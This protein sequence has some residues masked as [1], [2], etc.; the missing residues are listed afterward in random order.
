MG[1]SNLS[2]ESSIRPTERSRCRCAFFACCDF[3]SRHISILD[4]VPS[5]ICA[6]SGNFLDDTRFPFGLNAALNPA[7]R[8]SFR[9]LL[10]PHSLEVGLLANLDR[11]DFAKIVGP[12]VSWDSVKSPQEFAG[13]SM[14]ITPKLFWV[15][16]GAQ[17]TC[18]RPNGLT[19]PFLRCVGA[20][21][22]LDPDVKSGP[23]VESISF[24]EM[25]R[26]VRGTFE[27]NFPACDCCRLNFADLGRNRLS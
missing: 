8:Q 15:D 21:V 13:S 25:F 6:L 11:A 10:G 24:E 20:V 22:L 27:S 2:L 9:F 7:S 5:P 4:S 12:L 3:L 1:N 16:F 19:W 26:R 23:A 17:E 18:F 14:L